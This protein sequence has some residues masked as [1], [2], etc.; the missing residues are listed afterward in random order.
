LPEVPPPGPLL[1]TEKFLAPMAATAVIVRFAVK[2]VE[3][4]TVVELIVIPAPALTAV[5][6]LIK[7]VPVKTTSSVCKRSPLTGA[8][9]SK[10]GLGFSTLNV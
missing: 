1:V 5:T 8:M 6:P 4:F 2:F 3:L 7:F 10:V 9:L